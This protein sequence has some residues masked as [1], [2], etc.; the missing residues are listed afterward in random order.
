[1]ENSEKRRGRPKVLVHKT[2]TSFRLSSKARALLAAITEDCGISQASVIEMA[3][4]DL[5]KARGIDVAKVES[6]A[7]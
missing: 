2:S 4:R 7:A 6:E 1:M 3:L 5:A